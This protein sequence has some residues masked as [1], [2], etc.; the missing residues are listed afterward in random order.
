MQADDKKYWDNDE[1]YSLIKMVDTTKSTEHEKLWKPLE[2]YFPQFV[3]YMGDYTFEDEEDKIEYRQAVLTSYIQ[4]VSMNSSVARN[5]LNDDQILAK[6]KHREFT[7]M[8]AQ[9]TKGEQ[10]CDCDLVKFC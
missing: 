8:K 6:E 4:R 3:H 7:E 1:I 2:E 10:T 9:L 5:L